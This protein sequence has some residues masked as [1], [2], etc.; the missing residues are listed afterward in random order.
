MTRS[1]LT[2]SGNTVWTAIRVP[3]PA[4]ANYILAKRMQHTKLRAPLLHVTHAIAPEW[5]AMTNMKHDCS[6]LKEE[7]TFGA[8]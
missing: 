8:A 3:L 5:H 7:F 2:D 4:W 6:K 1:A